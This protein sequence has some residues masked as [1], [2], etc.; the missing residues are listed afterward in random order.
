[1]H[2]K[3]DAIRDYLGVTAWHAAG[4]TGRRGLT[5]SG[6]DFGGGSVHARYTLDAFH[7][8]APD[9]TVLYRQLAGDERMDAIAETGADTMFVSLSTPNYG[10]GDARRFDEKMPERLFLCVAAGNGGT[11]EYNTFMLPA[12]IYGVGAVTYGWSESR[13]GAP[14]E[15]AKL[16]IL[17]A[18][19][20]SESEHVDFACFTDL[21]LERRDN[22]PFTGTSCACPVLAG[23]AALVN[24][25]FIDRTGKPLTHGAMYRFLKDCAEDN[26]VYGVG[27]DGKTGWGVPRLPAPETIEIL[28]PPAAQVY[29]IGGKPPMASGDDGGGENRT[30]ADGLEIQEIPWKWAYL[31]GTRTEKAKYLVLHHAAAARCT[32]GDIHAVHLGNGWAGIAYHYFVRK[33]GS[34]WRGRPEDWKGGHTYGYSN[35]SIGIC[36]EGDFEREPMGDAQV[37]A[38]AALVLDILQRYPGIEVM[39]HSELGATSCPGKFFRF[40]EV[41]SGMGTYERFKTYMEQYAQE[42]AAKAEPEWSRKEGAW[43][44]AED[45]GILD[46]TRPESPVKRCELAA[47]LDRLGLTGEAQR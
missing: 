46:G 3:N 9:R 28:N 8:I 45:A 34:V 2:P 13:N 29:C 32:A 30:E 35:D 20:S 1:M 25:F 5:L 23:L 11:A 27:R 24:D 38:G 31:P 14:C 10:A 19:Y 26:V 37:D 39:R 44:R 43:K 16:L 33:D 47:V 15:G 36:F 6:E 18:G 22:R 7:E 42:T 40:E 41:A 12:R 21:V 17:P 4:Y